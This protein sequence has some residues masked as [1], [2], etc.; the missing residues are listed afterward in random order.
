MA[1]IPPPPP[2]PNPGSHGG[3]ALPLAPLTPGSII[4][5]AFSTLGEHW[6][7]LLGISAVFTSVSH[8]GFILLG[9]AAGD[10][11]DPYTRA[12]LVVLV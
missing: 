12:T 6:K 5:R 8:M 7:P 9:L 3:G 10:S 11:A 2:P 1:A 4:G